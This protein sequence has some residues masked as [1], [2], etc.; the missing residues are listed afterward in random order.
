MSVWVTRL[1]QGH[2]TVGW[3]EQ[4]APE[5]SDRYRGQPRLTAAAAAAE[6]ARAAA[7][8]PTGAFAAGTDAGTQPSLDLGRCL[9][10][11]K[12]AA[13]APGA[14]SFS[15]E[16]RLAAA[17]RED[18]RRTAA[19]DTRPGTVLNPEA[20][21]RFGRSFK[22]RQVSA[23]GCNACEADI[24]VLTT[25]VFDLGRFGVQFVASP[26]HADGVLVTGPVS[27]NMRAGL[28]QTWEAIPAPKFL[29][30]VGAC[31][32]AGGPYSGHPEVHNG[33][34]GLLPVDLYIPGCPPHPMT[35]LDGILRFLG[36][37]P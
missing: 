7:A 14:V 19:S 23:G 18:L 2:R 4:P 35:I 16:F 28:L 22:L 13:A 11:G 20:Q 32:I 30:V 36:R 31:A 29:I 5:L 12:C 3:P 10:C 37:V 26:R 27:E 21:R 6:S 1:R 15:A 9:F 25:I 24:N 17:R 34:D 33:V 8:C